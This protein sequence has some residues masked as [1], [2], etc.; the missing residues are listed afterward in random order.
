VHVRNVE[1]GA[2]RAKWLHR[3]LVPLGNETLIDRGRLQFRWR[4]KRLSAAP[5]KLA[6]A[7]PT[8]CYTALKGR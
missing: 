1:E 7:L 6:D 3:G 5:N 8:G 2:Q 4:R